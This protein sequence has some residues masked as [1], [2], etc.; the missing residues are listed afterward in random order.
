[1]SKYEDSC[2]RALKGVQSFMVVLADCGL[3][4]SVHGYVCGIKFADVTVILYFGL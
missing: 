3:V 4:Q 2:M 1:M